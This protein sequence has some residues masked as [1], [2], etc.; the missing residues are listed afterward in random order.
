MENGARCRWFWGCRGQQ[1]AAASPGD[2]GRRG[3]RC[4]GCL[5]TLER[6]V[7]RC[8]FW[9]R[10]GKMGSPPLVLGASRTVGS[11][12]RTRDSSWSPTQASRNWGLPPSY[13]GIWSPRKV[14]SLSPEVLQMFLEKQKKFEADG[15]KGCPMASP[16]LGFRRRH[17]L[18]RTGTKQ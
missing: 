14:L 5:E 3:L 15:S 11:E 8:R 16:E 12:L 17:V 18:D 1:V 6:R 2:V 10:R 9:K 7:C 13:R 4:C